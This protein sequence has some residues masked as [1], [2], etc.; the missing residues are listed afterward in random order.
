MAASRASERTAREF[1]ETKQRAVQYYRDN[2]V[3]EKIEDIL[4]SMFYENPDDVYGRLSEYFET[5]AKPSTVSKIVS[6]QVLDSKGQPTVQ[7]EVHC[8]VKGVEKH[9][10][11]TSTASQNCIADSAPIERREADDAERLQSVLA[12]VEFINGPIN[13]S[14]K[15][16]NPVNQKEIDTIVNEVIQKLKEEHEEK[17]RLLKE[18]QAEQEVSQQ[19][20]NEKGKEERSSPKPRKKGSAKSATVVIEEPREQLFSGSNSISAVSQSIARS[21]AIL[22]KINL[23]EHIANL[24]YEETPE[25]YKVPLPMAS[26]LSFGKAAACKLNMFK[27]VLIVP[28]PDKPID[29]AIKQICDIYNQ[30][31]KA[32]FTKFGVASKSVNDLGCYTPVYDKPEQALDVIQESMTQLGLTPAEDFN[33]VLNCAAHEM[34]DMDK[35]KYEVTTGVF[36]GADDMADVYSDLVTRYPAIIGIIDPIRKQDTEAWVKLCEKL[37]EKCYLMGDNIYPRTERFVKEGFGDMKASAV[38]LKLQQMTTISDTIDAMKFLKEE[39]IESVISCVQAESGDDLLADLAVGV[40]TKFIKI[41]APCRGERVAIFNRLLQIESVLKERELGSYY[42]G[43]EFPDIIPP[44]PPEPDAD[45]E[46]Q[47]ETDSVSVDS[48]KKK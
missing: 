17:E 38:V 46:G 47:T 2:Q 36:K 18:Q 6:R 28:K 43:H 31:G 1:Y 11:T 39:G 32:L 37:S 30:V 44:P 34:F 24:R 48:K 27:E 35:G 9:I 42:E 15:G 26:I 4:N 23:F 40:G 45:A 5:L 8:I 14:V 16:L 7:T 20:Q 25:K 13:E 29:E 21:A 3:P 10:T 33:I 41:G 19:P 12:A 22:S